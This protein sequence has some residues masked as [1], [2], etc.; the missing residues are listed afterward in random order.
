[1]KFGRYGSIVR[2][3]L[4]FL[5]KHVHTRKYIVPN[6][7]FFHNAVL[8]TRC[9]ERLLRIILTGRHNKCFRNKRVFGIV[10]ANVRQRAPI[11][12]KKNHEHTH[13]RI[14]SLCLSMF[15]ENKT[16]NVCLP[17]MISL[18]DNRTIVAA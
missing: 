10:N 17:S 9:F 6:N 7:Q 5:T 13:T 16:K 8:F 18:D 4:M 12:R 14:R 15:N 2:C 11:N 3:I 1:M